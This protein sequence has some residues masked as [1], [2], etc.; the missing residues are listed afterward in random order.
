MQN[1]TVKFYVILN[2]RA[3]LVLGALSSIVSLFCTINQFTLRLVFLFF[4]TIETKCW[5]IFCLHQACFKKLINTSLRL[6][7]EHTKPNVN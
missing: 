6:W 5:L 1:V 7:K 4:S 2:A 3:F